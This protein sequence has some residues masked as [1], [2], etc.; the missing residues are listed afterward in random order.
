MRAALDEIDRLDVVAGPTI[1]LR[2]ETPVA[3]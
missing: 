3:G 2:V 1:V